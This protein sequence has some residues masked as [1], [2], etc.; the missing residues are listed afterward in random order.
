MAPASGLSNSDHTATIIVGRP[1]P[2]DGKSR[3]LLCWIAGAPK[4]FGLSEG[5]L[6]AISVPQLE[7]TTASA[8]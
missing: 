5:K 4:E 2:S 8:F 6:N 1:E 7:R 3:T